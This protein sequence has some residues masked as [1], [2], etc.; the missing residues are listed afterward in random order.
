MT[1]AATHK[2]SSLEPARFVRA[3]LPALGLLATQCFADPKHQ[4]CRIDGDCPDAEHG[5][6]YCVQNRCVECV[7][8]AS[9][10]PHL[11]CV[12]GACVPPS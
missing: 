2:T 3:L 10:G 8:R 4:A 5:R 6:A 7:T 12:K 11:T 9:C 1:C